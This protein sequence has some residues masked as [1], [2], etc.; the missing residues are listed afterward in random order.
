MKTQPIDYTCTNC[1]NHFK[2][3]DKLQRHYEQNNECYLKSFIKQIWGKYYCGGCSYSS[4][5]LYSVKRHLKSC[6]SLTDEDKDLVE[7]H[8]GKCN[9]KDGK[10]TK[11]FNKRKHMEEYTSHVFKN[12]LKEIDLDTDSENDDDK[13]KKKNK[14]E[15]PFAVYIF[16]TCVRTPVDGTFDLIE[17]I[18]FNGNK[19]YGENI[20]KHLIN[21]KNKKMFI[22]RGNNEKD[23][24]KT[25]G[26][27]T[28]KIIDDIVNQCL[29]IMKKIKT[30]L[31]KNETNE[32]RYSEKYEKYVNSIKITKNEK[33]KSKI[34]DMFYSNQKATEQLYNDYKH[35][36]QN[37]SSKK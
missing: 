12:L 24:I 5:R 35:L 37:N 2:D 3:R 28:D 18:Y 20:N 10:L 8:L 13:K 31:F 23:V 36:L 29:N 34:Y 22:Y 19:S 16:K 27:E 11:V 25:V 26:D 7:K 33:L 1:N 14:S 4:E 30:I 17:T 21:K 15:N 9:R 6:K 32:K